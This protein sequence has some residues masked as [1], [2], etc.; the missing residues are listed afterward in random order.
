MVIGLGE[1]DTYCGFQKDGLPQGYYI[2]ALSSASFSILG[3][4]QKTV[5]QN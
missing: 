2:Q 4:T 1:N 3:E 5:S